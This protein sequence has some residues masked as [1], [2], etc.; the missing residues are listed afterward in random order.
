M[1]TASDASFVGYAQLSHG[2][3]EKRAARPVFLLGAASSPGMNRTT[4]GHRSPRSAPS[5]CTAA[6]NRT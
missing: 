3:A 6:Q 5:C 2:D 4:P 1:A